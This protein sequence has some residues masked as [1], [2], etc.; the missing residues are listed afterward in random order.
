MG[1]F[2]VFSRVL[3][4]RNKS[5]HVKIALKCIKVCPNSMVAPDIKTPPL[6]FFWLFRYSAHNK[7]MTSI[8]WA[9]PWTN[10]KSYA[11]LHYIPE[12]VD[13]SAPWNRGFALPSLPI[14]P[15]GRP[16]PSR[17]APLHDTGFHWRCN[18]SLGSIPKQSSQRTFLS[19]HTWVG[20]L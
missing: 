6:N 12:V 20:N 2:M 9:L 18:F 14:V 10:C 7:N 19:D 13:S 17:S 1:V 15:Q 5:F 16:M 8:S 4:S 11:V 3:T